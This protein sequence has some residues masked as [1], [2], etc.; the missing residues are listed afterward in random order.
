MTLS[1]NP[2][3]S[4]TT[5]L[6]TPGRRVADFADSVLRGIG[7]V[8]LQDNPY[9]GLLFLFGI[10]WASL[11]GAIAVVVGTLAGT[12]TAMSCGADRTMIR[13]GMFGFNGGLVG[14]ALLSFLPSVPLTWALIVVAASCSTVLM[15]AM[16]AAFDAWRLP[17]LTMPFVLVSLGV[18]LAG[19]RF[20]RLHSLGTLPVAGLP[21]QASVDGV[22]SASTIAQGLLSGIGQVF[23]QGDSITGAVFAVG[24][25]ISSRRGFAM[26]VLGSLAGLLIAWA[27]GA[28]EP[29]IRTGVYGFNS[30]LVAIAL[31]SVF[32]APGGL[33]VVFAMGAALVT[34]FVV[35]AAAAA[36]EPLG[37]P[38]MTMPFVL[39]TWVCIMAGGG[40]TRLRQTRGA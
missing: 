12:L 20:G 32:S 11:P 19:A 2:S 1:Q 22:V 40:L 10:A 21:Q 14:I 9:A 17:A 37:V 3:A 18:F 36:L 16:V 27:M 28:A 31:G 24:L 29:A 15:A 39:V 23:F 38:A 4:D 8:M 13:S 33:G 6:L 34:P 35:A 25:L 7:Q 30:V 26:A 5:A